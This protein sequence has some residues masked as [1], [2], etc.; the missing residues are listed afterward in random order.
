MGSHGASVNSRV[1]ILLPFFSKPPS[2]N[3]LKVRVIASRAYHSLFVHN[4]LIRPTEEELRFF[5]TPDFTIY[6]AGAFKAN[7]YAGNGTLHGHTPAAQV[8][9]L[10]DQQHERRHQPGA[11]GDGHPGHR[12]CR[13]NEK[14]HLLGMVE[15]CLCTAHHDTLEQI[16]HYW[17]PKRGV[18]SLHSGCNI[19]QKGDVTLFFGLSGT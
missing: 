5:G 14:G 16:M 12:V 6:N 7:R 10:H 11:K 17:M 18:L 1:V 2:Q 4:M 15:S 9:Q 13:R 19:G 3:R 8:Y